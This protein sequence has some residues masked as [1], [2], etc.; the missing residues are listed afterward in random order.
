MF[1]TDILD[2]RPVADSKAMVT[3]KNYRF[4]VLTDRMIRMEWSD[5]GIFEDRATKFA[6]CRNLPVPQ[7]QVKE[8]DNILEIITERLH[9]HYDKQ[10]FS[11]SGLSIEIKGLIWHKCSKWFYDMP[12]RTLLN[13]SS[14]MKGTCCT[15]DWADGACELEDGLLDRHGFTTYD[16]SETMVLD[17]NG[18]YNPTDLKGHKDIY[19]FGY[20]QDHKACIRDF[21]KVSG[22]TPM[23]PRYALGN[24]WSRYYKYTE[25][26]YTE[27]MQTF[28]EKQVP[29]AVSVVDIDWHLIDIDPKYGNGW[30]GYTWN[31]EFFPDPERFMKWLHD[32]GLKVTLN[33]HPC[34]GIRA[35][36]DCY[37][38]VAKEMGV[39]AENEQPIEFDAAS[40]GFMNAYLN[41]VLAPLEREGVDFWWIDWQQ[42]GGAGKE[43]CD[44]LWMLNHYLYTFGARKDTY[45]MILSRY[46]GLGSHRYPVGFSGDTIM[47]WKSLDFQPYFT[48]CASNVG[49]GWWSHDIGGHKQGLWQDDM[50]VRWAQYGVFSPIYRPHSGKD[51]FFLKEPWNFPINIEI[52]L[53]DLMR[54]RHKLVP[55]LYTMNYRNS[56]FGLPL[57]LPLYYEHPDELT[58]SLEYENEYYFGSELLVCPITTPTDPRSGL[59]NVRAY[60]PAGDWFDFFTGRHYKG[61]KIMMLYRTIENYPVLAKAGGIIPLADDGYVNGTPLPENFKIRAFAGADGSFELYED[62]EQI[63]NTKKAVTPFSIT[64]GEKSVFT[65]KGVRG[66]SSILPPK[67]KYTLEFVG[68][69]RPDGTAVYVNGRPVPA[70]VS[71]CE[72]THTA[73]VATESISAADELRI[74]IVTSGILAENDYKAEAEAR[75]PRYQIENSLKK[76]LLD[77]IKETNNRITLVSSLAATGADDDIIGEL[78]EIISSAY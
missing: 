53:E 32:H 11:S 7:F 1:N 52:I 74:E 2:I 72:K 16:D 3:G 41:K 48:N 71:Y 21:Y 29:L 46:A 78:T 9:L 23:L 67:R 18:W 66:D 20:L 15:L 10:P 26:S 45:P 51:T 56:A 22:P 25:E 73:S 4:T 34:D 19:F 14:N 65:K 40:P 63:R 60:I 24:W 33:L 42:L 12:E 43:G 36:E 76:N 58:Y 28:A 44:P 49:Y 54:L 35:F 69:E 37:P 47:S 62:D 68:C 8:S 5:D 39:D 75:L 77:Q 27:L 30:T 13:R 31:R 59:G 50:Q 38:D 61:T 57:I 70:E 17:E 6:V 64:W 55:Y